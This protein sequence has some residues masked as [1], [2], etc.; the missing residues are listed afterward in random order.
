MWCCAITTQ[1]RRI[2]EIGKAWPAPTVPVTSSE[3]L[4]MKVS[5]L[6]IEASQGFELLP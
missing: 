4:G 1:R 3:I 5:L 2:V 6:D